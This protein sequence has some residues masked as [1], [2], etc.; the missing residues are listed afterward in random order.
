MLNPVLDDCLALYVH[1]LLTQVVDCITIGEYIEVLC[2][3]PPSEK[4]AFQKMQAQ[5][6]FL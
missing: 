4:I 3:Y 1:S 5:L 2:H 6:V